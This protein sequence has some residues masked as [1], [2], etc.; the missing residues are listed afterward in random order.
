LLGAVGFDLGD[1]LVAYEGVPLSWQREYPAALA[2]MGAELDVGLA[3]DQLARGIEVLLR[4]NT[5][6]APRVHEVDDRV[7]FGELL[8]ALG[9]TVQ[10]PQRDFD[11]CVDAFFSV[12]RGRAR[13]VL[14]AVESVSALLTSGVRVGVLTDVAY[15]MPRRLV[16]DDLATAGLGMLLDSTL[17]SSDVGFR[18]P[19]P[20]GFLALASRLDTPVRDLVFVGNEPKDVEGAIGAGAQAVL[21]WREAAPVPDWGQLLTVRSLAELPSVLGRMWAGAA[22]QQR[23]RADGAN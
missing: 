14:G 6:V 13:V 5:R 2:A 1:T 4:Y 7:L 11:R 8:S 17:T 10:L 20:H 16:S 22:A 19:E 21:L 18:K 23:H 9:F 3:E 12:F 15:A